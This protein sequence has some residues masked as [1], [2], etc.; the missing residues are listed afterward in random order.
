MTATCSGCRSDREIEVERGLARLCAPCADIISGAAFGW[1][2]GQHRVEPIRP[3]RGTVGRDI[4]F[5][6]GPERTLHRAKIAGLEPP[7][8]IHDRRPGVDRDW[9]IGPA[10]VVRVSG[11]RV[12]V[13]RTEPMIYEPEHPPGFY[14][15]QRR[16]PSGGEF[17]PDYD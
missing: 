16:N 14:E 13:I 12:R 9:R 1:R 3:P 11:G 2:K 15:R 6:T 10:E 17:A 8:L 7:R 5:A 4:Y